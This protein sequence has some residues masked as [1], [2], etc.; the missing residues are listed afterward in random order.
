MV[1]LMLETLTWIYQSNKQAL[2]VTKVKSHNLKEALKAR[3]SHNSM[4]LITA[5][6]QNNVI[7]ITW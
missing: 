2:S 1:K 3:K 4:V 7:N 5:H 6:N